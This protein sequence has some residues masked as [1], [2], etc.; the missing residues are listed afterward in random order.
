MTSTSGALESTSTSVVRE[1]RRS[2]ILIAGL[3]LAEARPS[4]LLITLLRFL[5][6]AVLGAASGRGHPVAMAGGAVTI[7]LAMFS[8]YLL[9]GIMDLPE[10]RINGSRRPLARGALPPPVALR[11]AGGAAALSLAGAMALGSGIA[12]AVTV[13]LAIGYLYSGPP[14]YLKRQSFGTAVTGISFGLL[15]YYGGK[16]AYTGQGGADLSLVLAVF[17]LAM[18]LWIGVVGALTKDLP[19]VQGDAEA[20]R[21]TLAVVI[22]EP[23]LRLLISILALAVGGTFLI[24][25][26]LIT[27]VL[28]WLAM[29]QL[30]GAIAVAALSLS[31]VSRGSRKR[32]RRPYRAFMVTQYMIN[33][34][35]LLA[36]AAQVPLRI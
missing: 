25:A 19:D 33:L 34:A 13:V 9:N 10:D 8:C 16:A 26:I 32:R 36:A 4:V 1:S 3:C 11:V 27:P 24:V 22:N 30:A 29:M 17:A 5:A 7:E 21:R 15:A 23:L 14:W 31:N 6:G 12:V 35:V 18:S 20:G 28:W 2:P